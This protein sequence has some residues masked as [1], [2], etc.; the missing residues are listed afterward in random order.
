MAVR[1]V[2]QTNFTA[3]ELS[4]RLLGRVD[5][6]K[7][8][9][10]CR[11][12][13]NFVVQPHGPIVRRPGFRYIADTKD[14]DIAGLPE[15]EHVPWGSPK[16]FRFQFST[17][18]AYML[19]AGGGY[20]RFYKNKG[21]I[22]VASTTAS[23]SNPTWT[24]LTGWVDDPYNPP[25][26]VSLGDSGVLLTTSS[27]VAT[28]SIEQ[29]LT[30]ETG[31][32]VPH[33]LY[34]R[35]A[36]GSVNLEISYSSIEG[37]YSGDVAAR[38]L[39]AG[40]HTIEFIPIHSAITVKFYCSYSDEVNTASLTECSFLDDV[41]LEI[42][43][44]YSALDT[45]EMRAT[46]TADLMYFAHPDHPLY[47]LSRYGHY[48]WSLTAV[49]FG[50]SVLAPE[51]SSAS[52]SNDSYYW[53][54]NVAGGS[55]T[56]VRLDSTASTDDGE[57]VGMTIQL[58]YLALNSSLSEWHDGSSW[59]ASIAWNSSDSS[60]ELIKQ[61]GGSY[62]SATKQGMLVGNIRGGE[63]LLFDIQTNGTVTFGIEYTNGG[64]SYSQTYAL[65][66][67]L[68]KIS[69]QFQGT[70]IISDANFYFLSTVTGTVKV[71]GPIKVSRAV[72]PLFVETWLMEITD[73]DGAYR[74]C[75]ITGNSKNG[76]SG[77][78]FP[79][80]KSIGKY[81]IYSGTLGSYSTFEYVATAMIDGIESKVSDSISIRAPEKMKPSITDDDET[82]IE[83]LLGLTGSDDTEFF[84][85][86]RKKN[87]IF[88]YIGEAYCEDGTG[89]FKDGGIEIDAT[90]PAPLTLDPFSATDKYPSVATT[91]EQRLVLGSTNEKP[92][93]VWLSKVADFHNFNKYQPIKTDD[94]CMFT[95]SGDE[96]NQIVWALGGRAL[97]LGTTAG[98][99]VMTSGD[100]G[101]ID[102]TSVMARR[103]TMYGSA[104][105][106]AIQRGDT[107]LYV[108]RGGKKIREMSWAENTG[109]MTSA[110]LTILSEHLFKEYTVSSMSLSSNPDPY[111]YVVRT[112]GQM[113]VLSYMRDQEV[114]AWS[115]FTTSGS[116]KDVCV[117][118]GE[119]YDEVWIV[120]E[121]IR[122]GAPKY[123]IEILEPEFS[124][125]ET[126][127]TD[128]LFLDCG[129]TYDGTATTT[130]TGLDYLDGCEVDVLGDGS[131]L[132]TFTV[133]SGSIT[134]PHACSVVQVGLPYTST[135][136]PVALEVPSQA[137]NTTGNI[138]RLVRVILRLSDTLGLKVGTKLYNTIG[139]KCGP[140]EFNLDALQFQTDQDL[141]DSAPSLWSGDYPVAVD[142]RFE[143]DGRLCIV[144]DQPLP[145]TVLAIMQ[146]YQ[147]FDR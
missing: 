66:S 96:V 67:G 136:K 6:Q 112:D 19:E 47:E 65:A 147:I 10:G 13:E 4:P 106:P 120:A 34:V 43:S 35:V 12:L 32:S 85:I 79:P 92:Q 100:N 58:D 83:V 127:A 137:G 51:I 87:G 38:T 28:A 94:K 33:V 109:N 1:N 21:Q 55:T 126:T 99:W 11:E 81:W 76:L 44:P 73:Y 110:D 116:F 40:Y 39:G 54:G 140:D 46:Q 121:R 122:D 111:L 64:T 103:F 72:D 50:P 48:S 139:L 14:M 71:Y 31:R 22:V 52:V 113:A 24:S 88:Y 9:N 75:T 91:F 2:I 107:I 125:E 132:G 17:Q 141:L 102:A 74:D 82:A 138:R 97:Y 25:D 84:R 135:C 124:S 114:V 20:F 134:L 68:N 61:A 53:S 41:P 146:E 104:P 77:L 119:S 45:W 108:E 93:S 56:T 70:D 27:T 133:A 115:R 7:Y 143:R 144:Q 101:P 130:I 59:Y 3:G 105:V 30:V 90:N 128:A 118:N 98:E 5:I 142:G 62:A 29:D 123:S 23:V 86:Y 63:Y 69:Y 26:G 8:A 117:L 37:G 42:P 16:L 89:T 60:L 57:Y 95:L 36:S 131:P 49:R 145:C 129:A 18:Q 78:P 15:D 80:N